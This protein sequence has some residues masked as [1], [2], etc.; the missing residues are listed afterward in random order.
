M[1]HSGTDSSWQPNC[2]WIVPQRMLEASKRARD[3]LRGEGAW[4][5]L[6]YTHEISPVGYT[7]NLLCFKQTPIYGI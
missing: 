1:D 7:E 2:E 5:K 4:L 6:E 3:T